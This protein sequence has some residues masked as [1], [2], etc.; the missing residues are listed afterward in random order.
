MW[1]FKR[2]ESPPVETRSAMQG[3][4]SELLAARESYLSG[5][6][7][8]AEL[9]GCVQ[10]AISMWEFGLSISEV[11]G[12]GGLLSPANLAIAGR[13]LALSGESVF[14]I[15]PDRI[16]P[17]TAWEL[18]TRFSRPSAYKLQISE[19][20]GAQSVTALSA[21]VLHFRI[22]CDV[23]S[24]WT[25][26]SPLRRARLTAGLLHEL[27]TALS[28]AYANMPL[29][30]QVITFP[31]SPQTDLD[32]LGA[33][34]RARR[35]RTLLKESV[36]VTSAGGPQP[37]SDWSPSSVTPDISKALTDTHLQQ[38]K[39]S[40]LSCFGILPA[41]LD[42]NTTGPLVREGQRHL[43]QW[44]LE[45]IAQLIA[46]EA[47]EKLDGDVAISVMQ[48]LQAFDLGARSRS[49]GAIVEALALAKEKGVD[50]DTALKLVALDT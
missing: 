1:P 33:G 15:L 32:K 12:D 3:F 30:S 4:T 26:S 21:E 48:P 39:D 17:V 20:S 29:G 41:M 27:E 23:A 16:V 13:Q 38:A 9:T 28:E 42:R 19:S 43:A 7:N 44:T 35:G 34:F 50:I 49:L 40:V 45:P 8:C 36:A 47:S 5:R 14:Y 2:K 22:G 46:R 31:E 24:P 37:V 11:S 6:S 10:S 25:G 18:A